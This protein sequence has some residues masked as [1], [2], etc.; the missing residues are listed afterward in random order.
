MALFVATLPDRSATPIFQAAF[1]D[2]A[3]RQRVTDAIVAINNDLWAMALERGALIVDIFNF[4]ETLLARIDA[5]GAPGCG[6]RSRQPGSVGRRAAP[7]APG[8]NEHTGTVG[9]GLL[10][11]LFIES[12]AA[13]GLGIAP[14]SDARS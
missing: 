1:P 13:A 2:P 6:R 3:E 5:N 10:A 8:D 14:F 4:G 11:N 12:F 9:S 7:P